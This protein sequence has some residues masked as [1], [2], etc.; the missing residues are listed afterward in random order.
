MD[1]E[2]LI[3]LVQSHECLYDMGDKDYSNNFKK[4]K[5]WTEIGNELQQSGN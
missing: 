1:E 5:F 4:D 2:K 3:T